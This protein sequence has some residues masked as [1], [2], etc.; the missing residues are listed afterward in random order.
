MDKV[1]EIMIVFKKVLKRKA[2]KKIVSVKLDVMLT[3]IPNN[4]LLHNVL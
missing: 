4:L 3:S 2:D 1:L